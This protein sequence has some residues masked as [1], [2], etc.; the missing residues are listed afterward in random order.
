MA[1]ENGKAEER[2]VPSSVDS[3]RKESE[4]DRPGLEKYALPGPWT[5]KDEEIFQFVIREFGGAPE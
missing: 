3:N 1:A 5:E 2:I 4:I